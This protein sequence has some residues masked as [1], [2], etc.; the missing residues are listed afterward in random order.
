MCLSHSGPRLSLSSSC[1]HFL[2]SHRHFVFVFTFPFDSPVSVSYPGPGR[3]GHCFV[4]LCSRRRNTFFLHL[5]HFAHSHI[6]FY[7]SSILTYSASHIQL[8]SAFLCFAGVDSAPQPGRS[9]LTLLS[10]FGFLLFLL[11]IRLRRW[12]GRWCSGG[13][14]N[15]T[16]T[17]WKR[18]EN[19]FI[20][21]TDQQYGWE[22]RNSV[23]LS[24]HRH[25]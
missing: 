13:V 12:G 7:L 25:C 18:M 15:C 19:G 23:Y 17:G 1:Q 21:Y 20:H 2:A 5:L 14:S 9:C 3:K 24:V 10:N 6:I 8:R 4:D 22:N 11:S 16:S